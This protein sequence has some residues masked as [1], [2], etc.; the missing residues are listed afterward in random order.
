VDPA[1]VV[2]AKGKRLIAERIRDTAKKNDIPIVEDKPLARSLYDV[3]EPGEEIPEEFFAAVAEI[4]A[5]VYSLK[6]TKVA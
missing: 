5:Y 3:V 2:V 1:P 6:G 4:L